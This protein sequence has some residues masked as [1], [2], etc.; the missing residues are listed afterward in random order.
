MTTKAKLATERIKR[1][2]FVMTPTPAGSWAA[3]QLAE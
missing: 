3:R 1:S 2:D